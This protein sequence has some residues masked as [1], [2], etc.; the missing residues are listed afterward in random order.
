MHDYMSPLAGGII[1][2]MIVLFGILSIKIWKLKQ[3]VDTLSE[4]EQDL[5]N[6]AKSLNTDWRDE[7][8]YE[9]REYR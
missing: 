6:W 3:R 9:Y 8:G 1:A 4:E 2:F 5:A 7:D